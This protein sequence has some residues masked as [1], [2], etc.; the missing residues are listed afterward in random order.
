MSYDLD[1]ITF[2]RV[3]RPP[4][5]LM[6]GRD[7]VG[8]STF[9]SGAPDPIYIPIR[10]EEGLDGIEAGKF[11]VCNTWEDVISCVTTLQR[12]KHKHKTVVFDSASTLEILAN[13]KVCK[14]SNA[15]TIVKAHGG[16]GNGFKVAGEHLSNLLLW[17]DWL[18]NN[19]GMIVIFVGHVSIKSS[20]DP[21]TDSYDR[22][23]FS[24]TKIFGEILSHWVDCTLFMTFKTIVK[25]EELSFKKEKKRGIMQPGREIHTA[26]NADNP[27]G[28]RWPYGSLPPVITL[29]APPVN[30]WQ[31]FQ[32]AIAA[33]LATEAGE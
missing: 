10:G 27:A 9:P 26:I 22:H 18:R 31:I 1:S 33:V 25:T 17:C 4:R 12:D 20:V 32:D 8:K 24:A 14:D 5:V 29:K 21:S 2:G 19:K 7:K 30:S 28:G 3:M 16:Y 6:L 13:E 23:V 15:T 11:P